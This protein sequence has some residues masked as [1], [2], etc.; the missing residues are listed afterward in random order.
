MEV[1][2]FKGTSKCLQC[3]PKYSFNL[4]SEE[5]ECSK[6]FN[7]L[8]PLFKL[9][10]ICQGIYLTSPSLHLDNTLRQFNLYF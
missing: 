10:G 1:L 4:E 3:F 9:S 8:I 6:V 5:S 7:L 2:P